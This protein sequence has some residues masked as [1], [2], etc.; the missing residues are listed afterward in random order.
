MLIV[1]NLIVGMMITREQP[2]IGATGSTIIRLV[3]TTTEVA[4]FAEMAGAVTQLVEEHVRTMVV[5]YIGSS[6]LY[7]YKFEL[8]K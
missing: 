2:F 7:N 4:L 3:Q 8:T 1:V 6:K 5:C